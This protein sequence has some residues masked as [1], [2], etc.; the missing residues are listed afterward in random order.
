[1]AQEVLICISFIVAIAAISTI[2]AR[3]IKQP[4]IIAY[5]I[6]GVL[7]GPLFFNIIGGDA[8]SLIQLFAHIGVALLLFIIGLSKKDIINIKKVLFN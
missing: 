3:I 8:S 7:A 2:I 5:L 6:S 1:M 4:P